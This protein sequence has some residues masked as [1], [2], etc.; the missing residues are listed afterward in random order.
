M[1]TNIINFAC[2]KYRI[3]QN[4]DVFDTFELDHQNLTHQ[5]LKYCI[6]FT[7]VWRRAVTICQVFQVSICQNFALYCIH[8]AGS[9]RK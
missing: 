9:G 6:A 8:Q 2:S 4:F 7:G 3:A 5:L 1:V